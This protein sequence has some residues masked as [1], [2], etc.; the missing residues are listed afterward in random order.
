[1]VTRCVASLALWCA[2]FSCT[3]LCQS[4]SVPA[5]G[6]LAVVAAEA[7]AVAAASET[8]SLAVV[9]SGVFAFFAPVEVTSL[10]L[11]QY[12]PVPTLYTKSFGN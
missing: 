1:M 8:V 10:G 3:P 11:A 9:D 2:L 12:L 6:V 7:P 5:A 4:Q